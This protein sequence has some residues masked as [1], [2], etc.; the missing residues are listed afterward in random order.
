MRYI[1]QTWQ[2]SQRD[3]FL[4][5]NTPI[6]GVPVTGCLPEEGAKVLKHPEMPK[7]KENV[8][9]KDHYLA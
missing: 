4:S 1:Y 9:K 8:L 6:F 5:K 2:K 3:N 7:N